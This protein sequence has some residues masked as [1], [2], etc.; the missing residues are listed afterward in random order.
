[1]IDRYAAPVMDKIQMQSVVSMIKYKKDIVKIFYEDR[2][3][4]GTAVQNMIKAKKV[5]VT[6]P[7]GVLKERAVKFQ[8]ALPEL[9]RSIIDTIGFSKYIKMNMFWNLD[10]IFWDEAPGT[11][12]ESETIEGKDLRLTWFNP[13]YM[14]GVQDGHLFVEIAGTIPL[15]LEE[16]YS[17]HRNDTKYE[18]EMCHLAMESLRRIFGDDISDPAKVVVS[19]WNIDPFA[20]GTYSVNY[21]GFEPD[22]RQKLRKPIADKVFLSGE[23]TST[24]HYATAHGAMYTGMMA[25]TKVCN[26]LFQNLTFCG[27]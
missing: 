3:D 27:H 21:V 8:P 13:S 5:I 14:S 18:E 17:Q 9:I 16:S 6:L 15:S 7:L 22:M 12:G 4:P 24:Y 20:Y 1:M 2:S 19:K 26:S 23:A 10:D 25:A 11:F